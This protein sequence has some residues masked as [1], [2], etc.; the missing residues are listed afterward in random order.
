MGQNQGWSDKMAWDLAIW[1]HL[2]L[3]QLPEAS[4]C[5]RFI[6]CHLWSGSHGILLRWWSGGG[7]VRFLD[8]L[9]GPVWS[10][11]WRGSVS[12]AR[13]LQLGPSRILHKIQSWTFDGRCHMKSTAWS[14]E[15]EFSQY[16]PS[17]TISCHLPHQLSS[18]ISH[19]SR[20]R[21]FHFSGSLPKSGSGIASG[22]F[23]ENQWR[24]NL[25]FVFVK[26]EFLLG[27]WGWFWRKL[28]L[29]MDPMNPKVLFLGMLLYMALNP[30][31]PVYG[32]PPPRWTQFKALVAGIIGDHRYPMYR[33]L[34]SD[35]DTEIMS[36]FTSWKPLSSLGQGFAKVSAW[37][38]LS[39]C[40][41]IL[42][43]LW[44]LWGAIYLVLKDHDLLRRY[45]KAS[46][47]E[48]A[49]GALGGMRSDWSGSGIAG[50]GRSNSHWISTF[51]K[52]EPSPTVPFL[53]IRWT[54]SWESRG[55]E[56][57]T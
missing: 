4:Q 5:W 17:W 52:S 41:W 34:A 50:W 14:Q 16:S 32:G 15:P 3:D 22:F 51:Q 27:S 30:E 35:S 19:A 47:P 44:N 18:I 6:S 1:T 49:V 42:W 54:R 25:D 43:A 20:S 26:H 56:L 10:W 48:V 12:L 8:H 38:Y 45:W 33:F 40:V 36:F 31:G 21:P 46:V 53:Q 24:W 29:M 2:D 11:G 28:A 9:K 39:K 13:S 7:W 55:Q 23:R 57:E 37:G